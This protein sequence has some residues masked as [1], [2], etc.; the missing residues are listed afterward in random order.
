MSKKSPYSHADI[1]SQYES[2]VSSIPEVD[3]KGATMPYT[4]HNGNM[5][6]FLNK[7]GLMGLRL[8]EA[9]REV[10]LDKYDTE[11]IISHN[12][13]M[14]EYVCVPPE[15]FRKTAQ[16]KKHFATSYAY[17]CGLKAK[18]TTRKKAASTTKKSG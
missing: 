16:M 8:G 11:L 10:F 12:T 15:L 7:E 9:D 13:V 6:S 2:I 14:K 4:S 18:P 17:V 1:L 3:R 5:F